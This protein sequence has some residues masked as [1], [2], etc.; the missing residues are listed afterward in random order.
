MSKRV[1]LVV[2]LATVLACAGWAQVNFDEFSIQSVQA[3]TSFGLFM[4]ALD[5]AANVNEQGMGPGFSEL[6]GKYV[7]GGLSNLNWVEQDAT[8]TAGSGNPLLLGFMNAGDF[9]YSVFTGTWFNLADSQRKTE[10]AWAGEQTETVV[11]GTTST[12][13]NWYERQITTE[14]TGQVLSNEFTKYGQFNTQLG[15]ANVGLILGVGAENGFDSDAVYTETTVFQYNDAGAGNVPT[16]KADF[17]ETYT[18]MDYSGGGGKTWSFG[19]GVPVYLETGDLAHAANLSV[20][21]EKTDLSYTQSLAYTVPQDNVV[22]PIAG[23]VNAQ[24]AAFIPEPF[25]P[26][27]P[28]AAGTQF[29]DIPDWGETT[30]ATV[31]PIGLDYA[32]Y[33]PMFGEH[34]DNRLMAGL[35]ANAILRS[36]AYSRTQVWQL[37]DFAVGG[38]VT[39]N[40]RSE[41]IVNTTIASTLGGAV[42]LMGGHSFYFDLGDAITFGI[43]P[44][45]NARFGWGVGYDG[46][47]N[48][49]T[50]GIDVGDFVPAD[51]VLESAT[52]TVSDDGDT[53]GAF[54]SA[55]DTITTVSTTLANT[56][57]AG[58]GFEDRVDLQQISTTFSFP[59]SVKIQPEGWS[60]AFTLGSMPQV[61]LTRSMVTGAVQ[62]SANTISDVDGT[63]AD[64]GTT[65]EALSDPEIYSYTEWSWFAVADHRI[66]LNMMLPADVT[67][68]VALDLSSAE[69]IL[70][71]KDF[72]IQAIIPLP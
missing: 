11:D 48:D 1:V 7:F 34:E 5:G 54:T 57:I 56:V 47:D 26:A 44:V 36:A 38:A 43:D 59:G 24:T 41:Y 2:L 25:S 70:D 3:Y 4:N 29:V 63:G 49:V 40:E 13:Y 72:I 45:V 42:S 18:N 16:P 9:R 32:L 20:V 39:A 61:G 33:T 35:S 17:T 19:L 27:I 53:D 55:A 68:D 30:S 58:G 15:P 52:T 66:A 23:I 6:E 67:I 60:F 21:F 31:V 50:N 22:N 12:D 37:N 46:G 28:V 8:F 14:Y 65:V 62:A 10:T 71:F 69:N 51:G 64:L